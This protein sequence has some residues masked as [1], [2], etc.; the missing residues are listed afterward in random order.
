MADE[1]VPIYEI[2]VVTIAFV[3]N[4]TGERHITHP[5]VRIVQSVNAETSVVGKMIVLIVTK[6]TI[7]LISRSVVAKIHLVTQTRSQDTS[8]I[9][10][11]AA[12]AAKWQTAILTFVV[13]R[14]TK[15]I[16]RMRRL[17]EFKH[18]LLGFKRKRHINSFII[19]IV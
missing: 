18:K 17:L 13:I 1:Q 10:R 11:N 19:M 3:A 14:L 4:L 15:S 2:E 5:I 7:H 16:T 8:L 6:T 9:P 12:M